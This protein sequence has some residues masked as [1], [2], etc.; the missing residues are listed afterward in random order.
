MESLVSIGESD[1]HLH[2]CRLR[3]P[4]ER[5]IYPFDCLSEQQTAVSNAADITESDLPSSAGGSK[6][7][8]LDLET[9]QGFEVVN[10]Q[11]EQWGIQFR[12]AIALQPSN[13]AYPPKTGTMV[14]IAGP[15]SGWMEVLFTRPISAMSCYV[16]SSRRITLTGFDRHKQ[17]IAYT[18]LSEANLADSNAPIAP[19]ALLTLTTE[20]PE[21]HRI[22]FSAFDGQFSVDDFYFQWD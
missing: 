13:P 7:I 18:E 3:T 14:L 5:T 15:K 17:A 21:I 22:N 1:R 2:L 12:N 11:F 6:R 8:H 10:H 9:L 4:S 20:T 19:N 16:T